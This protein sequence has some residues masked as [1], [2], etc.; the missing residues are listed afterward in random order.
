MEEDIEETIWYRL[1]NEWRRRKRRVLTFPFL[2]GAV[3]R[4]QGK[5][6]GTKSDIWE[7]LNEIGR[8][9]DD[10]RVVLFGWC[11]DLKTPLLH[12]ELAEHRMYLDLFE[13]VDE[14]FLVEKSLGKYLGL[15]DFGKAE[16]LD[17]LVEN[18]ERPVKEGRYSLKRATEGFE[19]VPF[20]HDD[21]QLI[22]AA[23]QSAWSRTGIVSQRGRVRCA[24]NNSYRKSPVHSRYTP[25]FP[26]SGP[27]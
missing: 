2:V 3:L 12:M 1:L 26:L 23:L 7:L 14:F 25:Q 6:A 27:P 15:P 16:L 20:D 17:V 9:D 18:A 5:P 10:Q 13:P 8:Q 22:D 24:I 19:F 4:E 11:A 21:L